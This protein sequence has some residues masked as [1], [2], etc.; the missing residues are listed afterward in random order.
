M[1]KEINNNFWQKKESSKFFDIDGELRTT[2]A[3][4]Y[5]E[6][7]ISKKSNL[8]ILDYGCGEG[9]LSIQLAK[10][11][12][13]I[14]ATD[15]SFKSI[16]EARKKYNKVENLK[17]V[18]VEDLDSEKKFDIVILSFVLVTIKTQEKAKELFIKL[19]NHL[20]NDGELYF[21]DTHPCFRDKVF[22]TARTKFNYVN[23]S[24]NYT[25]FSVELKDC[26]DENKCIV[27]D[28]YHKSLSEIFFIFNKTHFQI[29]ML[30]ELYDKVEDEMTDTAKFKYNT[31]VPIYIFIEAVPS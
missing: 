16:K 25:S 21:M 4:P 17:F 19:K 7:K 8:E 31:E 18:T 26:N 9:D 1:A 20:K 15:I 28:D 30:D 5:L 22:S 13:N 24:K 11:G 10:H 29:K 6:K 27:F 14:T 12:N 3:H 23:Y 2:V